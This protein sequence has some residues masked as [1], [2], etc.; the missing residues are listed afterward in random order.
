MNKDRAEGA[1]LGMAVGD[2]LGTTYEFRRI[3]QADYPALATGPA[4]DVVGA[5]PFALAPGQITDDTQLAICIAR[6]FIDRGTFDPADIAAKYVAWTAH[7]FDIGSQTLGAIDRLKDGHSF[8]SAGLSVWRD[9]DRRP[10]GNG[11][12]MRTAPIAVAL[13]DRPMREVVEAAVVESM[14][15]HAD[16]RCVLAC[17]AF[18]AAIRV[19]LDGEPAEAMW[20]AAGEATRYACNGYLRPKWTDAEDRACLERAHDEL[21]SDLAAAREDNPRVYQPGL[22]VHE[23]AGF[24]RVAFRLAFW[25]CAHTRSWRDAV[26]DVA[27]RGGDADT[28]A[29]IVGA[30]LGARDGANAIP[31][32]WRARVLAATQPGPAAWAEAHHPRHLLALVK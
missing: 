22:H 5:G 7:A 32:P 3:E 13:G 9:R 6:S 15:T 12:L 17:A 21:L 16:P 28:N 20:E 25:H 11:S 30:L 14:I 19:A 29:A 23:T 18:D 27:S 2:A 1:L 24:V 4:T 8:L 10:A 31:G 26:V